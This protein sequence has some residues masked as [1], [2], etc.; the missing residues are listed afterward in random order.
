MRL[1]GDSVFL[2]FSLPV[3]E[4]MA[5]WGYSAKVCVKYGM[6]CHLLL[7]NSFLTVDIKTDLLLYISVL[8]KGWAVSYSATTRPIRN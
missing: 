7:F 2:F 4:K 5:N 6:L 8:T 3:S 1:N